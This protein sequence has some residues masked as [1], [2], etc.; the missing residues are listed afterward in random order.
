MKTLT[1]KQV[2]EDFWEE[3]RKHADKIFQEKL[4]ELG[5]VKKIVIAFTLACEYQGAKYEHSVVGNQI[6]E[7]ARLDKEWTK[8]ARNFRSKFYYYLRRYAFET[9]LGWILYHDVTPEILNEFRKLAEEYEYLLKKFRKKGSP[10]RIVEIYVPKDYIIEQISS[11]LE[12]LKK[13]EVEILNSLKDERIER[14]VKERLRKK[15]EETRKEIERLVKE[16]KA[17]ETS[18]GNVLENSNT[19]QR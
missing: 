18:T 10:I 15:L 5:L 1:Q 11:K 4:K 17:L 16:I 12:I 2:K 14:K 3:L 9:S 19:R 13:D 6:V 8:E 7:I